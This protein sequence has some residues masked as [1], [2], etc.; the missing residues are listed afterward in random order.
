VFLGFMLF[1]LL[2]LAAGVTHARQRPSPHGATNDENGSRTKT[3]RRTILRSDNMPRA[4][5]QTMKTEQ[6]AGGAKRLECVEL[7]PAFLRLGPSKSA[8]KPP[9]SKR[10]ARRPNPCFIRVSSVAHFHFLVRRPF[11]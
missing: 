9:H 1:A 2:L 7:A 5:P 6:A 8:G 3:T 11:A 4:A 10:L